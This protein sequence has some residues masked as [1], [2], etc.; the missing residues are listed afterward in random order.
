MFDDYHSTRAHLSRAHPLLGNALDI[1]RNTRGQPLSFVDKPSL[2]E[3]YCELPKFDDFVCCKAVQTGLSELMLQYALRRSGWDGRICAYVLPTAKARNRFVQS[4]IDPVLQQIPEYRIR[5]PKGAITTG[6]ELRQRGAENLQLKEFGAGRMLF[7]GSNAAVDFLEFSAD[8]LIIDELDGCDPSNLSKARNRLRA[9]PYPQMIRLGNPTLP[10]IGI[11]KAFDESD[12]RLY[13]HRCDHCGHWQALDWFAHVVQKNT[14]GTW[15]PRDVKRAVECM[16]DGA[17]DPAPNIDIRPVCVRCHEPFERAAIKGAWVAM[18]P[19]KYTVGYRMTR[20]DVLYPSQSLWGLYLEWLEAQ[21]DTAKLSTFY[22]DV[23]GVPFAHGGVKLTI[24]DLQDA[25]HESSNDHVG[26]ASL[27]DEVVTMGVDVG[28]VI[29]IQ[30]SKIVRL[31]DDE[32]RP[33]GET[34]REA[35]YIGAVGSFG[36]VQDAILRYH[37]DVCVIDER[38]E[39]HKASEVRDWALYNTGCKVWLCRFKM[40]PRAGRELFA[41]ELNWGASIVSVDRTSLLDVAADEVRECAVLFPED[42]LTVFGWSAQMMAPSR[43]L[44][45]DKKRIV[46]DEDGKADHYFFANAYDRMALELHQRSGSLTTIR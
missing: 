2:V 36:E 38:P 25:R 15:V 9:S 32:G 7:L 41:M 37:V 14:N 27:K 3:L 21:G 6:N 24:K 10:N 19:S 16:N 30:I 22:C 34:R 18:N 35:V 44:D 11:A 29:N 43:R 5:T 31:M 45:E 39:V 46:W 1:H 8:I 33:T 20:L 26:D 28:A 13:H 4:R 42:A 17:P 12:G 40:Q 23:L